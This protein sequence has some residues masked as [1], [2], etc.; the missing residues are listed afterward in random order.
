M[1]KKLTSLSIIIII[2]ACAT[3][4]S[5]TGG[6]KDQKAP[7]LYESNP[8]DQSINF[9]GKEIT[10]FFNEW[11]KLDQLQNEL[12]ITPREDIK[13]ESELKKQELIITLEEPLKDSTTYT[14]NF[15]SALKDI[16]EGNLWENPTIAFSTGP[17]LDS[18]YVEGNVTDLKNTAPQKGFLVGL[19]S[20]NYDTANLRQGK[21]TYFTTTDEN[22]HYKMQNIKAGTYK[23]YTFQDANNN[24]IND[25]S[26]EAFGFHSETVQLYDSIGTIDLN[27]Y[28]R[29]EDTLKLK[30]FSPVGKDFTI[31]YNKGLKS[32]NILNPNDSNQ[33]IYANDIEQSK[34]IKVYKDNF[35]N[36]GYQ[37]DSLLL[38]VTVSDSIGT[39]RTDSVFVKLRES[40]ITNDSIKIV[41]KPSNKIIS[42]PQL[43]K[44]TFSKPV[45]HINYDSIQL[46][47][48]TIPIFQFTKE[49]IAITANRK[50]ITLKT[51][52]EQQ[53]IEQEIDSLKELRKTL[54]IDS[55]PPSADSKEQSPTDST[56]TLNK[57]DNPTDIPSDG[58]AARSTNTGSTGSTKL[59]L[60]IG[61]GAFVGVEQDSTH[62]TTVEFNF[63]NA[64]DYG[65]IK[66]EVIA[67]DFP[68]VVELLDKNYKVIDTLINQAE[69]TFN[70]V[71]PGD[72]RL[73]L[74]KDTN[75]NTVWDAGNPIALKKAEEYIYFQEVITV[76]SNWEVIDK[77]FDF[78][79]DNEV[80]SGEETEDL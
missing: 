75:S 71:D 33:Y 21:P 12:I 22:G 37:T 10:L 65:I 38:M 11:M 46:R 55:I 23:I 73:R 1:I 51:R 35:P 57:T 61:E 8:K 80:D 59:K 41:S 54:N 36:L 6:E 79:V 68:F 19:Y 39:T 2:Y 60:F 13:F 4:Q 34:N 32:Y 50:T 56:E 20:N 67:A 42:G 18:L 58:R 78:S 63:K 29:N 24:L 64:E 62:A 53:Q 49:Q 74:L 52:L 27:T 76:K 45:A 40:R 48:D 9:N 14:F 25:P 31:Q 17:F 7:V 5:P 66:G 47:I 70:Y 15:R 30:K 72:Y 16:T 26:S 43:F 77:N 44:L 69:F 28:N 3:V